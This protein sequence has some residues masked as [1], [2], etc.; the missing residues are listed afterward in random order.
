MVGDSLSRDVEG[1]LA[2][3]L[4]AVWLNRR[5]LRAEERHPLVEISTLG[6]LGAALGRIA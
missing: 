3:G 4:G 1:A 6:H 5:R 2:A